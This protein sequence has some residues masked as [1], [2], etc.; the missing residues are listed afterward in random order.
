M[1]SIANCSRFSSQ[2]RIGIENGHNNAGAVVIRARH[3]RFSLVQT[4]S[5]A[6]RGGHLVRRAKCDTGDGRSGA[7]QEA[8]ERAGAFARSDDALEEWN[9][10]CSKRLV[11]MILPP[12]AQIVVRTAPPHGGV[13]GTRSRA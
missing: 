13:C 4:G 7:A 3:A 2:R 8:A 5:V 12:A 1:T 6:H 11:Q 10:L 9:K